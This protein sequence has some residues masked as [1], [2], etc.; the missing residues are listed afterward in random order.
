MPALKSL[1]FLLVVSLPLLAQ[2]HRLTEH[3]V[4]SYKGN[5]DAV[6][7]LMSYCDAVDDSVQ[8][9]Q[10]RIFAE[11]KMELTMKLKMDPATES[12]SDRWREFANKEEWDAVG[13]PAPLAFV[14]NRDGAIVRVTIMARPPRVWNPVVGA[15][16]R[17]DYCYGADTKLIRIRAVWYVPTSCEFLF[18]CRLISGHEFFLGGQH[19]AITDWLFTGDGQIQKLRNGKISNDPFD[20]SYSLSIN[21]L[22]RRT[23]EDL[24]FS[25]ATSEST[26]K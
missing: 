6:G 5:E 11:L 1:G 16:Q 23:S 9:Q 21:D 12:K 4:G 2:E 26:S 24:P 13:K 15:H 7:S 14:W 20:P 3:E 10:P 17:V 25:H 18:P 8:E 22:H 19:P